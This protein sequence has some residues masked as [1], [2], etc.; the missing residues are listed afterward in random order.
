[1][2]W[3]W[4]DPEFATDWQTANLQLLSE[5]NTIIPVLDDGTRGVGTRRDYFSDSVQH[6]TAAGSTARTQALA[7]TLKAALST[8]R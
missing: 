5:I 6:L 3:R 8:K 1:M 4:T 7:P 2:P